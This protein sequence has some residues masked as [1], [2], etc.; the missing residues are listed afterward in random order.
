[1]NEWTSEYMT[2]RTPWKAIAPF[3]S[4]QGAVDSIHLH[5]SMSN[6]FLSKMSTW[7]FSSFCTN[8]STPHMPN[9][10]TLVRST[11]TPVNTSFRQETANM[12]SS[13]PCL[14]T[15]R[16]SG[17]SFLCT[18]VYWWYRL[19]FNHIAQFQFPIEIES[20]S[21]V[22]VFITSHL[23]CWWKWPEGSHLHGSQVG[24]QGHKSD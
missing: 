23:C 12:L 19:N 11:A 15:R 9:A 3:P 8:I 22:W 10:C 16:G 17:P 24:W 13:D 1:M 4:P 20:R 21:H 6:L 18:H 7:W 5:L 2:I 14:Q